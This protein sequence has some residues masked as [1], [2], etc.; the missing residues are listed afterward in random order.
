MT[1]NLGTI[2]LRCPNCGGSQFIQKTA[3]G[4]EE[5]DHDSGA[6]C[7]DC[8]LHLSRA[9][10]D[11]QVQAIGNSAADAIAEAIRKALK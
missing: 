7:V 11:A 5:I 10:L 4:S 9:D 3:D 6:T 8:G 2:K 1:I